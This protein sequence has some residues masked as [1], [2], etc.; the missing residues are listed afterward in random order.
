MTP[1]IAISD[2]S[3][4]YDIGPP[5][6][7]HVSLMVE[8]GEFLGLVGPNGGGKSTLLKLVL[9][10]L[11]PS[12]GQVRVMGQTPRA[13]RGVIGYVPQYARFA[14]DFPISVEETVLLGR[15]GRTR[16]WGGWRAA[17]LAGSIAHA[18]LGG[19]GIAYFLGKSPVTGALIAALVLLFRK[20]FLAVCFDEEFARLRGVPVGV[21]YL[22]LLWIVAL[23][24]VIL[25]QVVGLIL[26]LALLTLPAAIAGQYLRTLAAMMG[27]AALLGMVFTTLGLALSFEPD[28]PAGATIVLLAGVAFLL[29]ATAREIYQRAARRRAVAGSAPSV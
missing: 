17:D 13:A 3:F 2:L 26:V 1:V 19:M 15:L 8:E 7:E 27:L 25:V 9:G 14:R 24:V 22:L 5:A 18:V 21:F 6:L 16:P 12:A 10:L 23:T 29:S 28:L 4:T 11:K 20:Q